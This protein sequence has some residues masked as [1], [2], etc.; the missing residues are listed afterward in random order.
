[1]LSFFDT[2]IGY[3]QLVWE[4][5]TNFL[6]SLIMAFRVILLSIGIP[7]VISG[8]LPAFLGSCVILVSGAAIIKLI[9]GWS[10]ES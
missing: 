3:F 10:G 9:L 4:F 2:V 7:Q 6:N 8:Y 1:M 5:F